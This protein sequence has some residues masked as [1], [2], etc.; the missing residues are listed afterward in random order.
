[1]RQAADRYLGT[2]PQGQRELAAG[3]LNSFIRRIGAERRI[4]QITKTD[5]DRYQQALLDGGVDASAQVEALKA[6]LADLKAKKLTESNLGA[7][8]RI[9]RRGGN[10]K[11]E[12]VKVE[13]VE[14]TQEGYDLLKAEVK[15]IEE[16]EIPSVRQELADAYQDRDFRENAP[17]DAAK[18][19]LGELTGR[20]TELKL[21]LSKAKIVQRQV[22]TERAGLGSRVVLQDLEHNEEL[23]YTLVGPGE[24]DTRKGRISIQ[25]PVGAA[26]KERTIGDVIEVEIPT[27]K[28]RYRI[29][30]IEKS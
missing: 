23:E 5:V 15:R 21:Q 6:F 4:D 12:R 24:V 26:I 22:S 7:V 1:M 25:S 16:D 2:L 13:G 29:D 8:L 19:R 27:G 14:L 3:E 18:R 10:R 11:T 17:Y 30:R 20:M 28:A 9:R